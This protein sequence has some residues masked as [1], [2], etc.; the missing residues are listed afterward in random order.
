MKMMSRR[1]PAI[2]TIEHNALVT[3]Y[4][5]YGVFALFDTISVAF[6]EG[7]HRQG[8]GLPPNRTV[9]QEDTGW[10]M[11]HFSTAFFNILLHSFY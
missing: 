11:A 6:R 4:T 1:W 7:I 9:V 5:F 8:Y 10:L 3:A 2:A